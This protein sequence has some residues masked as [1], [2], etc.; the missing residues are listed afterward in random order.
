MSPGWSMTDLGRAIGRMDVSFQNRTGGYWPDVIQ[1]LELGH[2]VVLQGDSDQFG[3]NT[4]SGAFNGDHAIGIHPYQAATGLQRI[5]DPICP[6]ARLE[7]RTVLRAYA[8]KLARSLGE[9]PRLR[10]GV[11]TAKVPTYSW[12]ARVPAGTT[13]LRYTVR[14]GVIVG[15]T[16]ERTLAGFSAG[17]TVPRRYPARGLPQVS[18]ELVKLTTGSRAGQYI[19]SQYAREVMS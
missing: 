2:Y 17:C 7:S 1:A 11:F 18:Y 10:Y 4:C 6:V 3:N 16:S 14:D 5:D 15:R 19:G 12:K 9:Y 8:E 13:F